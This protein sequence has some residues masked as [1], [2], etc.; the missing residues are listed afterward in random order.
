MR[1][2]I[3]K[4]YYLLPPGDY[5]KLL[6]LFGLMLIG[7]LTQVAGI[8]MAPA[9][10]AIVADPERI[11]RY[12]ALENILR[13]LQI[14]TPRDILIAGGLALVLVIVIKDLYHIFLVYAK[15][16]FVQQRQYRISS[17]LMSSYMQAPYTFHLNRNSATLLRNTTQESVNVITKVIQ[18]FLNMCMQG[19]TIIATV[20]LLLIVEPLITTVTI[21]VLGSVV[22]T[23]LKLTRTILRRYGKEK[24]KLRAAKIKALNQGVGGIKDARVL[25]REGWFINTFRKAARRTA[26]LTITTSVI[27]S[28]PKAIFE[29]LA[30]SGM[31][32]VA[33]IMVWQG[34][35]VASII[36]VMTL[37]VVATVRLIPAIQTVT[38]TAMRLRLN[39]VSVDPVYRDMKKLYSFRNSFLADRRK[40]EKLK[41]EQEILFDRVRFHYPRSEEWALNGVSF[42]I[43]KGKA[44]AFTGP[45]GSG[46]TTLVD[47]LL[48]LL[49]P[50]EGK[51]TVDGWDIQEHTSGWQRNIGYIPQHIFLADETLR[52]N[53]AFGVDE[54]EIDDGRV[55][56]VIRLAQLEEMVR[57]LPKGLD[58]VIGERGVR[59]SGGQRQR[60]GIARAL[61]HDPQVLVMDEATSALD[62]VTEKEI[63]KAIESLKG[64]RTIIMIA[65]RL[66]TVEKCDTIYFLDEGKVAGEGTY[67]ELLEHSDAFRK[68]AFGQEETG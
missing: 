49:V 55:W 15:A 25:N 1:S 35:P 59:L 45:S 36:P 56:E 37:F 61:Y 6:L 3:G 51:V 54:K 22:A 40:K 24:M 7:A 44:V 48:G 13:L 42:S 2:Y 50:V 38:S 19:L 23:I 11:M 21:L 62:N 65:H 34:R 28:I 43:P 30:V 31:M 14:E 16:R 64:D 60:V 8:G 29:I 12:P 58:T 57:K 67:E 66:T 63:I 17:E 52:S 9:F 41:M 46:K 27:G 10:V 5:K 68:L 32:L 18:P 4:I 26:Q 20:A 47:I 53:I 33:M 39:V